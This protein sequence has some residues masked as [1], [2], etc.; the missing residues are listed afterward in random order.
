MVEI[1]R[2]KLLNPRSRV[3][4]HIKE[5]KSRDDTGSCSIYAVYRRSDGALLKIGLAS[6]LK[7]RKEL[8]Y[9][10]D[11]G[12]VV[13]MVFRVDGMPDDMDTELPFCLLMPFLLAHPAMIGCDR[14][15]SCLLLRL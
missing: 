2:P 12:V 14:M 9:N 5:K 4:P 15:S 11:D 1:I 6:S 3:I 10:D 13:R 7:T 8:G